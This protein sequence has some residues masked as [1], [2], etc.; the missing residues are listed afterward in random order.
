M[1][2]LCCACGNTALYITRT[3]CQ[4]H[5]EHTLETRKSSTSGLY[6]SCRPCWEATCAALASSWCWN[7]ALRCP[8]LHAQAVS[9]TRGPW[10][11]ARLAQACAAG[12][13]L[14]SLASCGPLWRLLML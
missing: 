4:T 6:P 7:T 1:H 5:G 3:A 10:C 12:A 8:R 13:T 9:D 14:P 2:I 11:L